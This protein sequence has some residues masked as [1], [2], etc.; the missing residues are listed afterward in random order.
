M[1]CE[2]CRFYL[3]TYEKFYRQAISLEPNQAEFYNNLGTVLEQIGK[4]KEAKINFEKSIKIN[5][6]FAN[7]HR[8][9]SQIKKFK[10]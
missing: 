3:F 1:C 5:P 7:A 2:Q 9:L 6:G 8:Q 4:I 10:K